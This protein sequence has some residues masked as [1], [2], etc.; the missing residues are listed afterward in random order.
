M[1]TVVKNLH[2]AIR[3]EEVDGKE[4][5]VLRLC[6]PPNYDFA[7]LYFQISLFKRF[8]FRSKF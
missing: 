4:Y 1:F 6:V 3:E 8:K 7:L 5:G 2:N